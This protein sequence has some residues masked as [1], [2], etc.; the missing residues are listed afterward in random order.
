[1]HQR[2]IGS[3]P[4]VREEA[5]QIGCS[6]YFHKPVSGKSLLEAITNAV[7]VSNQ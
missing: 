7:H 5:R 1:L 4:Q 2:T 3:L 6:A